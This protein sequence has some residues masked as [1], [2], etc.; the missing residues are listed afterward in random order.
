MEHYTWE[1][2][3]GCPEI[4]RRAVELNLLAEDAEPSLPW[5]LCIEEGLET[6]QAQARQQLI[7][8]MWRQLDWVNRGGTAMHLLTDTEK[9]KRWQA[10]AATGRLPASSKKRKTRLRQLKATLARQRKR[11]K[12]IVQEHDAQR[13]RQSQM[14]IWNIP[15]GD[16][17]D[18]PGLLE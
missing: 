9:S 2:K 17:G 4:R 8:S 10:L 11:A 6:P 1:E 5:F 14:V 3:P 7:H 13:L 16:V 15:R 12:K 18:R